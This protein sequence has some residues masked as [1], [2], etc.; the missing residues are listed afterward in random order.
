MPD[1]IPVV[2]FTVAVA[3]ALLLQV[4][5]MVRSVSGMELP[6]HTVPA[7][8][9]AA[10]DGITVIAFVTVQPVP[11]EYIMVVVPADTPVTTPVS[12][13]IAAAVLLL[14][15]QP[16]GTRSVSVVLAPAHTVAAPLM[17]AGA[18]LTVTILVV[19]QPVGR[20]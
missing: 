9:M 2:G 5:P 4:P 6:L 16:P 17:G 15:H 12:E 18:G 7:P 13:P 11:N 20:V 8:V 3:V 14:S 1:V 10:G 19:L